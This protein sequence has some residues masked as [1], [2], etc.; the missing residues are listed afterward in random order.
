MSSRPPARTCRTVR[1]ARVRDLCWTARLSLPSTPSD[2]L[3]FLSGAF[4]AFPPCDIFDVRGSSMMMFFLCIYQSLPAEARPFCLLVL[5]IDRKWLCVHLHLLKTQPALIY[6]RLYLPMKNTTSIS[7]TR[8]R[9][10]TL[11]VSTSF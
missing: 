4:R 8:K 3:V 5:Y 2:L 9:I 10:M 6:G 1:D 7:G 11:A